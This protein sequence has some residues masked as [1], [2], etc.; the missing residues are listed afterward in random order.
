MP[1]PNLSSLTKVGPPGQIQREDNNFN[2]PTVAVNDIPHL[3]NLLK[4]ARGRGNDVAAIEEC[5][6]MYVTS[7]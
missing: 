7:Q 5:G 6:Y 4:E 2:L 1:M 3:V